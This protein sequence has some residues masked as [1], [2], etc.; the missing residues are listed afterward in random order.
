MQVHASKNRHYFL[1][2]TRKK[3]PKHPSISRRGTK[4]ALDRARS[5]WHVQAVA[6]VTFRYVTLKQDMARNTDRC[7]LFFKEERSEKA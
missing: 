1:G 3:R 6:I 7:F 5:S 4:N 2:S